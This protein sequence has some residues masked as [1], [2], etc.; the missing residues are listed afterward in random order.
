MG[1]ITLNTTSNAITSLK[2]AGLLKYFSNFD[3]IIG[4]DRTPRAKPDVI[5]AETLLYR[6]QL[7]ASEVC[8]IGDHPSDIETAQKVGAPSIAIVSSKHPKNE[9]N[10]PWWAPQSNSAIKLKELL[11]S[12]FE[13]K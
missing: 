9:F 12:Q 8:L 2:T 11:Q 4:R 6:M 5:H 13:L 3:Y 7:S 1:I 10:T